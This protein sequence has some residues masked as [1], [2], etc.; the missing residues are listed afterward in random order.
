MVT[1]MDGIKAVIY[2]CD[3]V[4]F[5]S[6]EANYAFYGMIVKHF[7]LPPLDR[8]NGETM[9]LLHTYSSKDVLARLFEGDPR[10]E[11]ALRFASTLDFRELV[12]LMRLEKDFVETLNRLLNRVSLAVCTNRSNSVGLLLEE[13]R[14]TTYFDYVM[15]AAK[16]DNPKPHPE[17]LLKILEH[18]RITPGEALFVGDSELDMLAARAAGI[19][20]VAYKAELPCWKR[21]DGHPLILPLLGLSAEA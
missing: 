12:P 9:H 17:P 1:G 6:F 19:P 4:M 10:G 2:D 5:D 7:G 21:I 13:F 16:V 8:D 20:F 18:Y 11:E 15:T 14:L 3:G